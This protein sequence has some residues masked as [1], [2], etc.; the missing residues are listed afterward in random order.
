MTKVYRNKPENFSTSLEVAACY[1]QSNKKLLF[2]KRAE[3]KSEGGKWGV[4]AGKIEFQ[5][6]P[7][8]AVL[9]EIFEETEI[10]LNEQKLTSLGKLYIQKK[11]G[12]YI[13]HLFHCCYKKIP[14]VRLNNEHQD[15]RWLATEELNNF[16]LMA[17]AIEAVH[18]FHALANKPLIPQKE[19]YFIRHG[20]TNVNANPLTKRV[21]YDLPLN[22]KGRLQATHAGKSIKK[23]PI[24]SICYSPISR[25]VETKELLVSDLIFPEK[26]VEDIK[27]C[28]AAIWNKMITFENG[29]G[30]ELCEDID[31]YFKRVAKGLILSLQS[32]SPTLLV[33]HGGIHFTLCYL[34]GVVDHPWR[35]NNCQF[36]HFQPQDCEEWKATIISDNKT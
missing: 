17:G 28:K 9:R 24:E 16:P 20:Q 26:K 34:L 21:D 3:N 5:E 8:D 35:I 30:Y 31:K 29:S 7:K 18:H 10:V 14:A 12:D 32:E 11:S 33:A 4:P 23:L 27:E 36:V 15:Y 19:F 6:T 25:A 2:L 22:K 13:Y 1:I